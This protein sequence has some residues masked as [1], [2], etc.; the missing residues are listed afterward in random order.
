[1]AK[2]FAVFDIDGTVVRTS[3]FLQ[4]VDQLIADGNLPADARVQLDKKLTAYQDRQHS[5]AFTEYT[6]FAV[7]LLFNNLPAVKV[8]DYQ[9]AADEVLARARS[10]SYVY[11]RDLIKTL[12]RDG[13]FLIALSR[14]E[15]YSVAQFATHYGFDVAV[16]ETYLE[17]DGYFTGEADLVDSKDSALKKLI[18]QHDL[19]LRD[20]LAIGDSHGDAK[21]LAMVE[22]PIAFNPEQ[23]LL[24]L[25]QQNGWKIV[26]E[27]K[28]VIYELEQQDG[29]YVLAAT[30]V[31]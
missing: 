27:R 13:Y 3:L 8:S 31:G 12:K 22:R 28:N 16:G 2:K 1:M 21:M 15:M 14:S 20:S 6:E 30:N 17:K 4:I 9:A 5:D 26:I 10:R 29:S 7:D 18:D 11:T 24:K 25:A 19:S 23:R